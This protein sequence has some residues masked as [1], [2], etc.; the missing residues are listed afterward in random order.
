MESEAALESAPSTGGRHAIAPGLGTPMQQAQ[1]AVAPVLPRRSL[2]S[3]RGRLR[4]RCIA[5]KALRAYP[6]SL[7][8]MPVVLRLASARPRGHWRA[9]IPPISDVRRFAF[10]LPE[11]TTLTHH[12][13]AQVQQRSLRYRALISGMLSLRAAMLS[14]TESVHQT[15]WQPEH[16]PG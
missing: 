7:I 14:E 13:S 16:S 1:W 5:H 10:H 6:S 8:P 4:R 12:P 2:M 11:S 15:G 9:R 3:A